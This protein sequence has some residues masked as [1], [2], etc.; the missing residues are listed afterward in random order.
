MSGTYEA[1]RREVLRVVEQVV[2]AGLVAGSSGNVSRRIAGAD[3]DLIAVTASSVPYHRFTLDDVVVVDFDI[4]PVVGDGVPS[5]ESLMHLAVYRARPD[6]GAVV[7]THSIYASA[8]AAAG[9][10]ILPVLDEQVVVLGGAVEVAEYGPS[11]SEELAARCVTALGE[12]A[13]VLLRNHGVVGVG[14]DLDEALAAVELTERVAQVQ[15]L[16]AALGGAQELPADVVHTEQHMYR[17]LHGLRP[18]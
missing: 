5:S 16:S 10:P 11:A 6:V 3:G 13:A 18:E 12:R 7:H 1:E 8:F 17:M 15:I 4:E 2:A 14:G 9:R